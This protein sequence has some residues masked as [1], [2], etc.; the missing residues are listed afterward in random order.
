[1]GQVGVISS[2]D[3][4]EMDM[5]NLFYIANINFISNKYISKEKEN[6]G[7]IKIQILSAI[8]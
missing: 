5:F 6:R 8:K 3:P 7:I 2:L 1:M 4:E